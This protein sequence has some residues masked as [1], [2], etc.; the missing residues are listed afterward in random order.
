MSDNVIELTDAEVVEELK[1]IVQ[2]LRDT[3]E[4]LLE[5]SDDEEQ[6]KDNISIA[7]EEISN[8]FAVLN[9]QKAVNYT[10]QALEKV[11]ELS[12]FGEDAA[13][14]FLLRYCL[15]LEQSIDDF[16]DSGLIIEAE[17][18]TDYSS[19]IDDKAHD[20]INV[21]L[22]K[23]LRT[24]YQRQLLSLIKNTDK[25]VP[26]NALNA[27][28]RDISS[29][30]PVLNAR[31]WLL[32][33]FYVQALLK[34]EQ[35]CN[36]DTH[37][38]LAQLD[39]RLSQLLAKN[40]IDTEICDDLVK[41][42]HSLNEGT[43]FIE[44]NVLM[45]DV[46]SISPLV[47]KRFGSA[48]K[49]E[50]VKIHEQLERVYLDQ[51]Q[52]L[53]LADSLPF[54]EKLINVLSFMGLKRLSLLT[55]DLLKSFRQLIEAPVDNVQF[56][57]IVSEFWVLESFLSDLWSHR[58]QT[59]PLSYNETKNWAYISAKQSALKLFVS[60]YRKIREQTMNNKDVDELKKL[61]Q[62]LFDTV[63]AETMLSIAHGLTRYF[64]DEFILVALSKEDL[65]EVTLAIEYISNMN[66]ENREVA[67]DVI[68]DAK[69]ILQKHQDSISM[70]TTVPDFD[71][72]LI[73]AFSDDL[74]SLEVE[75]NEIMKH[76]IDE[77]SYEDL[78]RIAHTF[79]GNANIVGL[80]DVVHLATA[81]E[82]NMRTN[83]NYDA[84]KIDL[85]HQAFI[86]IIE[87]FR[88]FLQKHS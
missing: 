69:V 8:V 34:N 42:I 41:V 59:V 17:I 54:L 6:E 72:D 58:S 21:T 47:Y 64:V 1:N 25:I 87:Q 14:D 83:H 65:L 31:D 62:S 33:S 76:P 50:L 4:T 11:P 27:L 75:F 84:A 61:Q 19:D 16:M 70:I 67:E 2:S 5:N 55:D 22:L 40:N 88:A 82:N 30:L 32:L 37:R 18:V 23:V 77:K 46:Y 49:D 53:R 12:A 44:N 20:E 43:D 66:F 15:I 26:L 38:I 60:Q 13:E 85:Y 63:K 35:T 48:L 80:D 3:L 74:G 7:L 24:L 45:Q 39:G 81:L 52:R 51:A 9:W 71:Q 28:S 36:V 57:E 79:R 78:I 73:N 56:N 29:V 10:Q 68:H 86:G